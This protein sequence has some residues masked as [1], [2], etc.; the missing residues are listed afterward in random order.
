[1]Q[2][3]LHDK[4]DES[5]TD[6]E[7][8]SS[9]MEDRKQKIGQRIRMARKE[10]GWTLRE[11]AS[12]MRGY[13]PS[14][15]SNW[16]QGLR[17]PG[18]EEAMEL[19][20]AFGEGMQAT[21]ILCMENSIQKE[22]LIPEQ[23]ERR[24]RRF[25][26]RLKTLGVSQ[27]DL[28]S[29][30]GMSQSGLQQFI[31]GKSFFTKFLHKISKEL[32]RSPDWCLALED[33]P[34]D[35]DKFIENL[36]MRGKSLIINLPANWDAGS[37]I[38]SVA[39]P[40][41]S[42]TLPIISW[43]QAGQWNEVVD[44]HPSGQSDEYISVMAKVGS[45]AFALKVRGDSMEPEFPDKSIIIVDPEREPRHGSYVVVRLDEEMEATFKQLI[46][47]GSR[48]YLKPINPRYPILEIDGKK[49]TISG[50]VVQMVKEYG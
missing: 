21:W 50:V 24:Y 7:Y 41:Q 33:Q 44:T 6:C 49:T 29:R 19:A 39:L 25:K 14:R 2:R 8:I 1:M 15:I 10:R 13:S 9:H 43:V 22:E 36:D 40:L 42:K 32:A 37:N 3:A 11:L 31:T 47:D 35:D 20:N 26:E 12:K 34:D 4:F 27:E 17:A 45:H 38:A 16:E 30:V 18:P 5:S 46:L 28:A 23:K 48:K